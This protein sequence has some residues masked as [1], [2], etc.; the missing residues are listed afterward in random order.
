MRSKYIIV[1]IIAMIV[2]SCNSQKSTVNNKHQESENDKRQEAF[3][4][5]YEENH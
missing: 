4:E 2:N 5:L 1:V 3:D